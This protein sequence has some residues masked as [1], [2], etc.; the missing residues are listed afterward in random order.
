MFDAIIVGAGPV[1]LWTALQLHKRNPSWKILMYERHTTY[2]RSHVLRLD[3]WSL[4][5]YGRNSKNPREKQFFQEI[6]GKNLSGIMKNAASSLYIRTN[7]LEAALKSY[8]L[9][10]G[11]TIENLHIKDPQEL[12]AMHPACKYFIAADGA[13]S[14]M[15]NALL[16]QESLSTHPLQYIVE[17]KYQAKGSV[18]KLELLNNHLKINQVMKHMAFEYVGKEKNGVTPVTLRFFVDKKTYEAIPNAT[19]KDPLQVGSPDIPDQLNKDIQSYMTIRAEHANEIQCSNSAKMTK[20]ILSL[21]SAKKFA[22]DYGTQAWFLVGDCAMGVPYFRALNCGLILGSR[23]GQILSS[24]SYP[25][26]KLSRQV[27][28][29]NFHRPLHIATEFT[30]ARGKDLGLE[31]YNWFRKVSSKLTSAQW[32]ESELLE[33][34]QHQHAFGCE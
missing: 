17:I 30:I 7:D 27:S 29:Y 5:L 14:P 19:F 31:S 26:Q 23:L 12:M 11:I 18:T 15:R 4:L 1:G 16:G 34:Y 22:I 9:D 33:K 28:I 13:H 8:A 3:H 20:L 10:S 21:Y 6:T 25:G 2:Q 24:K 32:E